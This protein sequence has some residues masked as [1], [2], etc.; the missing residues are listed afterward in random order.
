MNIREIVTKRWGEIEIL[1]SP[2]FGTVEE[3]VVK[4]NN[5]KEFDPLFIIRTEQ[6]S[7]EKITAG[8]NGIIE[9]LNVKKGDKVVPGTVLAHFKNVYFGK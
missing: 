8:L 7:L 5:V 1:T 9:L 6:G 2:I 4:E 3:V